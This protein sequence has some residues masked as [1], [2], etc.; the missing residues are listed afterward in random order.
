MAIWKARVS[1]GVRAYFK[2]VNSSG[3]LVP[4]LNP[5]FFNC[6]VINPADTAFVALPVSQSTQQPGVYY[7]DVPS[8]FLS[9]HG[10]G[11]YGLSL[12]VHRPS[13][14]LN[15]EVLESLEV[16]VRDLDDIPTAIQNRN[17]ILADG[18]PFNGAF[19]DAPI[20]SRAIPGDMMALTPAERTT[21]ANVIWDLANKIENNLTPAQAVRL[22]AAMLL[23]LVSGGPSTPVFKGAGVPN[24][25]VSMTADSSG[26]RTSVILTP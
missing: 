11:A 13:P 4:G 8:S 2:V 15:D 26:N 10:P 24:V 21:L 12:G 20:S 14:P 16:T 17:A 23:G 3:N 5:S 22:M 19:I 18:T 9:A 25:R 6:R 7:V 1:T